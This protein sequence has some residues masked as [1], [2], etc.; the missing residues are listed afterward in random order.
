MLTELKAIVADLCCIRVEDL[1]DDFNFETSTMIDSLDWIEVIFR[2]ETE[3]DIVIDIDQEYRTF[4]D[5]R[6]QVESKIEERE[7]A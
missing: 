1:T 5:L 3:F 6:R 7:H 2:L 4:G